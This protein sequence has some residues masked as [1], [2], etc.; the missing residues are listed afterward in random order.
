MSKDF[1]GGHVGKPSATGQPTQPF[2]LPGS[3]NWAASYNRM[4]AT[5]HGWRR[6]VNAYGVKAWCRWSE[7]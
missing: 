4:L 2:I 1:R 7:Q 3:I 6:L 5:S